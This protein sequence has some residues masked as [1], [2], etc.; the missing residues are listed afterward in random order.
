MPI[1][2]WMSTTPDIDSLSISEMTLPGSHNSGSDW[3]AS[4]PFF[5]PPPHWLAC[6]HNSF[7]A[8]LN[9]GSRALDIRLAY[10]AKAEGP[11]RFVV[12]HN[13]H[14]NSRTLMD[15]IDDVNSFLDNY[16]DEFIVLDFHNF[17]G[18]D[19]DYSHF[20]KM[21]TQFL[22]PR[23][24]PRQNQS[25]SLR[26]LKRIST[27]QRVFAAARSHWQLDHKLFHY[28]IDHQWS[29]SGVTNT[30]E[31]KQFIGRV[32]QNPPGAWQPWS[33]SAT[34]YTVLGGPVD[35]H[36][37]LNNWFD[38]NNSD[39]ILKCNIINADF[40]EESD[41]SELC[42]VANILKVERRQRG[43]VTDAGKA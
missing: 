15:L 38:L 3:R 13:G 22:G 2:N 34:S 32:M 18:E 19:F 43:A 25:L 41:L 29:G 14:R 37:E 12:H 11:K 35:I 21:M 7:Y 9:Y 4:Y 16:P 26:N 28:Y 5:G 17:D 23:L 6:Q 8:Q 1:N 30:D 42:R 27:Q 20:N 40:I 10:N 39:W 33:L 36:G 31:L 24:I